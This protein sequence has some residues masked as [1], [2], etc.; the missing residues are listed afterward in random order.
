MSSDS[1]FQLPKCSDL[2]FNTKAKIV[3]LLNQNDTPKATSEAYHEKK[4]KQLLQQKNSTSENAESFFVSYAQN[5]G[6]KPVRINNKIDHT[7]A[8]VAAPYRLMYYY[9]YQN[10]NLPPTLWVLKQNNDLVHI[11]LSKLQTEV[12]SSP[13]PY[14]KLAAMRHAM[15]TYYVWSNKNQMQFV[16]EPEETKEDTNKVAIM[17]MK[18]RE[19][20]D[21][22][23][24]KA[25]VYNTYLLSEQGRRGRGQDGLRTVLNSIDKEKKGKNSNVQPPG[26]QLDNDATATDREA[27][28]E[29]CNALQWDSI[30]L[31]RLPRSMKTRLQ[32][33]RPN[34]FFRRVIAP[35]NMTAFK[36]LQWKN[37]VLYNNKAFKD[38]YKTINDLPLQVIIQVGGLHFDNSSNNDI[39]FKEINRTTAFVD[40][41][42]IKKFQSFLKYT[43]V[44]K[45]KKE[46]EWKKVRSFATLK[47]VYGRTSIKLAAFAKSK[48][49]T[50]LD[51]QLVR[52]AFL[53]REQNNKVAYE[54]LKQCE[55]PFT[56]KQKNEIIKLKETVEYEPDDNAKKKLKEQSKL[57]SA[58]RDYASYDELTALQEDKRFSSIQD[59]GMD[60]ESAQAEV[61]EEEL[62][63]TE[64]EKQIIRQRRKAEQNEL[65]EQETLR[66]VDDVVK[67]I[68]NRGAYY[69]IVDYLF[70]TYGKKTLDSFIRGM[71]QY[72]TF[73]QV[74]QIDNDE[75]D[76][77][78]NTYID[79]YQHM[80]DRL[81]TFNRFN[82][83]TRYE[84]YVNQEEYERDRKV[85]ESVTGNVDQMDLSNDLKNLISRK[86]MI[87]WHSITRIALYE[88]YNFFLPEIETYLGESEWKLLCDNRAFDDF[89]YVY[90]L[91]FTIIFN[92]NQDI[93]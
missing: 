21:L 47:D 20:V 77:Y 35:R 60:I 53:L 62:Q 1:I 23:S 75:R 81:I 2:S 78:D 3:E 17:Q 59:G 51:S 15:M 86:T 54:Y 8:L 4:L 38:T 57:L 64:E 40:Q 65:R 76:F 80:R 39:V 69:G 83:T 70:N 50:L 63:L 18:S 44:R 58:V 16:E 43:V 42:N 27:Y 7:A 56:E 87:N 88:K 85:F 10:K 90:S 48:T 26:A 71:K 41:D 36:V 34:A 82:Y 45:I 66:S 74:M 93:F 22:A 14:T 5:Q 72:V 12:A 68:N 11:N 91:L 6:T 52:T 67:D 29:A 31:S 13:D 9:T 25:Q 49:T 79:F 37:A 84:Y 24:I 73:A 89:L 19:K 61:K 33:Y 28:T 32:K 92:D 30:D 46:T 55:E